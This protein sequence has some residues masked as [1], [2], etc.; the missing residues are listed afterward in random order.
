M[1]LDQKTHNKKKFAK[2][3]KSKKKKSNQSHPRE[4]SPWYY[5]IGGIERR[6]INKMDVVEDFSA[7]DFKPIK[8]YKG[9]AIRAVSF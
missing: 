1:T 9:K 8:K 7:K 6:I 2:H 4:G 3:S 5:L